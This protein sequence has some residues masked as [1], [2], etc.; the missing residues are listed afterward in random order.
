MASMDVEA[1]VLLSLGSDSVATLDL[2]ATRFKKRLV[3]YHW[4]IYK[5]LSFREKLLRYY[6]SRYDIP[7]IQ[8][9]HHE[10]FMLYKLKGPRLHLATQY[11]LM[12]RNT[13]M[14]WIVSGVKKSD[15]IQRRG[16]LLH[17]PNGIDSHNK[18]MYPITE[19]KRSEVYAYNK[20]QKLPVS[21]E[22]NDGW[23]DLNFFKGRGLLWLY[24]NYPED[25]ERIRAEYPDIEGEL[26]RA[27]YGKA[28]A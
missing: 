1:I 5:G 2:V 3:M 12:R 6:E 4:Y 26:V 22:Y 20:Q 24:D 17:L 14:E 9:P 18:K 15:S 21:P 13:G 25:Y 27:Q 19:W 23:H 28:G 10:S 11:A 8:L 16:M 7:I